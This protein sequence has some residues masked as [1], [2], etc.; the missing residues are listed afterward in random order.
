IVMALQMNKDPVRGPLVKFLLGECHFNVGEYPQAEVWFIKAGESSPEFGDAWSKASE[1]AIR[2]G[3]FEK[4]RDY[5]YKAAKAWPYSIRSWIRVCEAELKLNNNEKA[6]T[7]IDTA[8]ECY[9]DKPE[10][11]VDVAGVLMNLGRHLEAIDCCD[12]V[13]ERFP[14][15]SK[16]YEVKGLANQKLTRFD[17]ALLAFESAANAAPKSVGPLLYMMK[18]HWLKNRHSN[19][20][21][22]AKKILELEHHHAVAHYYAGASWVALG[23]Y[24]VAV[25]HLELSVKKDPNN[26]DTLYQLVNSLYLLGEWARC[27]QNADLLTT[28]F[29]ESELGWRLMG[30]SYF[31]LARWESAVDAYSQAITINSEDYTTRVD[32]AYALQKL[33]KYEDALKQAKKAHLLV[34]DSVVTIQ[35]VAYIEYDLKNFEKAAIGFEDCAKVDPDG[36]YWHYY[37]ALTWAESGDHAKALVNAKFAT[38]HK[39]RDIDAF[40]VLARSQVALG[41]ATE[42]LKS[43]RTALAGNVPDAATRVFGN[44]WF[45]DLNETD[46]WESLKKDFPTD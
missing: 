42:A 43:L 15:F 26:H 24:R 27:A 6:E 39:N 11:W 41:K 1:C 46:G 45:K 40:V 8:L 14:D 9:W 2:L 23:E 31:G 18:L 33:G 10:D 30:G 44:E 35:R 16:A 19:C 28:L 7:A 4:A 17:K 32:L 36:I 3:K 25:Q 34:P 20:I 22:T 29:P 12:Q 37:A 5:A 38:E 13:V 21:E